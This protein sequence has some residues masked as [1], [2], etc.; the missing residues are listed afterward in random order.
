MYIKARPSQNK[1]NPQNSEEKLEN[2]KGIIL[3]EW[4][5]RKKAFF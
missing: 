5:N 3:E 1:T 4:Y 2:V